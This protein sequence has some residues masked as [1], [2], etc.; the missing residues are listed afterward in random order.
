[1]EN[2][3]YENR[4]QTLLQLQVT[5]GQYAGIYDILK[6]IGFDE[7]D[8]LLNIDDESFNVNDFI[9][10]ETTK[11][12]FSE[13]QDK[14]TFDL[15]KNVYDEQGG[16]G[17][18]IFLW[19][20]IS[21]D[22]VKDV[23]GNVYALNLNQYELKYDKE[24][25]IIETEVKRRES[26]NKMLTRED[27][28]VNLF[29]AKD[30]D[31]NNVDPLQ[32]SEIY[33]Q[34]PLFEKENFYFYSIGQDSVMWRDNE[35]SYFL[36]T[37][38]RA[39]DYGLG[40][41]TNNL[42]GWGQYYKYPRWGEKFYGNF[43]ETN[44]NTSYDNLEL[45]LSNWKVANL[46]FNLE[47]FPFKLYAVKKDLSTNEETYIELE[48]STI[49]DN[50][51]TIE[52]ENKRYDVGGL[53]KNMSLTLLMATDGN[54][55]T[56]FRN[57]NE[58]ASVEIRTRY[59]TPLRRIKAVKSIDA[60]NTVAKLYTSNQ[61][62]VNSN[63]LQELNQYYG[64]TY[65]STG[66]LLRDIAKYIYESK[67][68]TSF[69]SLFY[70]GMAKLLALGFDVQNDKLQVCDVGYFFKDLQA[71]DFTDKNYLTN[72][73]SI[74][75]DSD[76]TYNVLSFG[77]S[78]YSTKNNGDIQNFN[79]YLE[80]STPIKSLKNKFDKKHN[81]IIDSDKIGELRND[82]SNQTNESDDDLVLIDCVYVENYLDSGIIVNCY[83]TEDSQ[84]KL[85]LRSTDTP[86]G[87]L[88]IEV[89]QPLTILRGA[90][91]GTFTVLAKDNLSITLDKTSPEFVVIDTEISFMV[92]NVTKNRLSEGFN[93]IQNVNGGE[94]YNMRHNPKYQLARWFGYY[95]GGLSK[96][97]DAENV[98]VTSYKNNSRATMSTNAD[99]PYFD[100]LANELKGD[101]VVGSDEHLGRLRS[102]DDV[103]FSGEFIS[104]TLNNVSFREFYDCYNN[105]RYGANNDD[106]KSRGYIS[107]QING[108]IYDVYLFGDNALNYSKKH[109]TLEIKGKVK[110]TRRNLRRFK[111]FDYTFD[112]TFE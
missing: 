59:K 80:A 6:P 7:L 22:E 86:F 57:I 79:T 89:G 71:Y 42:C 13:Y 72:T 104:V 95:G 65:I 34:D 8:C 4:I 19:F 16:D 68:N 94:S 62:S 41:N 9:L 91:L 20:E 40:V 61:I 74:T 39:D 112:Y 44:Q 64:Y 37:F 111:I 15:I 56:S 18:I 77:T 3:V 10:G 98:Q 30:L 103:Y 83:H 99:S 11:L 110:N 49:V 21:H 76:D 12:K 23:L 58:Q 52:I 17:Q 47:S 50:I 38:N 25:Q 105:W 32:P 60:L 78:K 97:L 63:I 93:H 31:E 54:I 14:S 45:E 81:L 109:N 106:K 2:I 69:K 1:M 84:G 70:D 48:S 107:I 24:K 73:L 66:L 85:N 67:L 101:I 96:K 82:T 108:V 75:N 36:F 88:A 35:K 29:S 26:Q 92:S 51:N 90:N 46:R 102:Y 100:L 43:I 33:I 27:V 28:T 87:G 55:N 5:D 53:G